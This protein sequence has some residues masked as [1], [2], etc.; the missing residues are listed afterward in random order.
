[1]IIRTCEVYRIHLNVR[2][3]SVSSVLILQWSLTHDVNI[4][5]EPRGFDIGLKVRG[6]GIGLELCGLDIG[7]EP[8]GFDIGLEVRGVGIGLEHRG[9]D[10][11]LEPSGFDIGLKA[12]VLVLVSNP[13]SSYWSRIP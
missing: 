8:R 7:L 12:V 11:G 5:L 13:T 9:L 6:V 10:I 3:N 4:C 1:V 2:S